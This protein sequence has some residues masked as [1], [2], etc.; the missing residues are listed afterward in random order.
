VESQV[1]P[2]LRMALEQVDDRVGIEEVHL[3]DRRSV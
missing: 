1:A 3:Q 2:Y